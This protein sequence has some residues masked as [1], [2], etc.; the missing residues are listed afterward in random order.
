[1]YQYSG[2]SRFQLNFFSP[3]ICGGAVIIAALFVLILFLYFID[4]K[5]WY[6]QLTAYLSVAMLFALQFF[7]G[8]TYSRGSYIAYTLA[9]LMIYILS[10]KKVIFGIGLSYF[11]TLGL[12]ANGLQRISSIANVNDGSIIN[13]LY[14]WKGATAIA[15]NQ[16]FEPSVVISDDPVSAYNYFYMPL[17]LNENYSTFINDFLSILLIDGFFIFCIYTFLV[18]S[19]YFLS[20]YVYSKKKSNVMLFGLSTITAYI[21]C[22]VFTNFYHN[23]ILSAYFLAFC[24]FII[25]YALVLLWNTNDESFN[26]KVLQI[27]G[28]PLILPIVFYFSIIA[29]GYFFN[30]DYNFGLDKQVFAVNKTT[31]CN[32]TIIKPKEK[33]NTVIVQLLPKGYL[34]SKLNLRQLGLHQALRCNTIFLIENSDKESL[35][36]LLKLITDNHSE[37]SIF[38]LRNIQDIGYNH[39]EHS[40]EDDR[41]PEGFVLTKVNKTNSNPNEL[42]TKFFID[43]KSIKEENFSLLSALIPD[44]TAKN[45][46]FISRTYSVKNNQK[47]NS[48]INKFLML[49]KK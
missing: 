20:I 26:Q 40:S 13:R 35:N 18:F 3:N 16:L 49:S 7:L 43:R 23:S 9:L 10:R 8:I 33:N 17:H 30:K 28:L 22:S 37:T 25:L 27:T 2:N 6:N 19:A 14:L 12:I 21:I 4:K 31:K 1:M 48:L 15:Y 46:V 38:L 11:V 41:M 24:I 5:K 44:I 47:I 45:T 34:K 36:D 42:K 29:T 32:V 39:N